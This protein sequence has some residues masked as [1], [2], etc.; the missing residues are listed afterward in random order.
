MNPK[1]NICCVSIQGLHPSKDPTFVAF[2]GESR[3]FLYFFRCFLGAQRI[4]G[5]VR[6][7][8]IVVVR[9]PNTGKRRTRLW[10]CI[11]R[12]LQIR[13]LWY[14]W[15]SDAPP[16]DADPE[17]RH[18]KCRL[19]HFHVRQYKT[20][21]MCLFTCEFIIFTKLKR[22]LDVYWHDCLFFPTCGSHLYKT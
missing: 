5:F 13:T 8:S 11:C 16:K 20:P 3:H 15:P 14:N 4:L 1:Q 2:E 7:R 6:P 12:R 10:G 22:Y 19:A 18:R 9:P 17:L 21:E